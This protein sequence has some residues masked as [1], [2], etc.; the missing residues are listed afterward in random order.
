M[1]KDQLAALLQSVLGGKVKKE[2]K[3]MTNESEV[4]DEDVV[5]TKAA[6]RLLPDEDP[7]DAFFIEGLVK[8]TGIRVRMEDSRIPSNKLY[9]LHPKPRSHFLAKLYPNGIPQ[10]FE[11]RFSNDLS[12]AIKE[13]KFDINKDVPLIRTWVL[14]VFLDY[15]EA[16][17][18][19]LSPPTTEAE[20]A[21]ISRK[22]AFFDL[23]RR[24]Q[25][26]G[27][28]IRTFS[29]LYEYGLASGDG[30]DY[31]FPNEGMF[32]FVKSQVAQLP[33]KDS[34]GDGTIPYK[35]QQYSLLRYM[36]QKCIDRNSE[37]GVPEYEVKF[38]K[39]VGAWMTDGE[40]CPSKVQ[41]RV[42]K[43]RGEQRLFTT[44]MQPYSKVAKVSVV[45]REVEVLE[46]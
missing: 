4:M 40:L 27:D 6:E 43:E 25:I 1:N 42:W 34:K 33:S 7:K 14:R 38:E 2:E 44:L 41:I 10:G 45:N 23:A 28:F 36:M 3:T 9:L 24:N 5:Q 26:H 32:K 22:E 17:M 30:M 37:T 8:C 35:G 29:T 11:D 21:L 15:S 39:T 46:F 20:K 12:E 16:K 19:P 18:S 13:G 31:R